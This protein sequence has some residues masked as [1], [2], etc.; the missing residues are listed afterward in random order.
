MC[1]DTIR[2][3]SYSPPASRTQIE[4]SNPAVLNP[5][6]FGEC[7]VQRSRTTWNPVQRTEDL[8][9]HVRIFVAALGWRDKHT[10][11]PVR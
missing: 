10:V 1:A 7:E 2:R 3:S 6:P 4:S 5:E 11:A 8:E 9:H